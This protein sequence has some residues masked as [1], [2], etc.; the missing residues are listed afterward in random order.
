MNE[1]IGDDPLERL[2]RENPVDAER[3][4][5][6]SLARVRASF[7]EKQ[8]IEPTPW[9]ARLA[10]RPRLAMA[11]IA[12]AVAALALVA[13]IAPR[14]FAPGV[15]PNPTVDPNTAACVDRYDLESLRRRTF[16][17]D[18]TVLTFQGDQ[19]TFAVNEA[20][21]GVVDDRI[22]LE[23]QGMSGTVISSAGGPTLVVGQ[24]YLVAGDARFVWACGF[25]Q[26]YDPAVA[27]EWRAA[28]DG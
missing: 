1:P 21:H 7:R 6:A 26:E 25:T 3:L 11:A 23:A 27:A 8:M 5:S 20:F 17:F 16:A 9:P 10:A 28:L 19:V 18:G 12:G 22:T 24:R 13:L 4:S 15:A 2:R 14:A